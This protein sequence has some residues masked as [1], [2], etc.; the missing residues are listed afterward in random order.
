RKV[1]PPQPTPSHTKAMRQPTFSISQ[2]PNGGTMIAETAVPA[3]TS[4]SARPRERSNTPTTA[5]VQ[6][7]DL[8]LTETRPNRNHS[9]Y[10]SEVEQLIELHA[11][12]AL[13]AAIRPARTSLRV[14]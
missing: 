1:T 9:R 10:H 11:L 6:A 4:P 7:V 13:I 8:M 3:R 14:P 12:F 2:L 5:A